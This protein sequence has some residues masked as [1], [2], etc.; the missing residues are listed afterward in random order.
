MRELYLKNE[1][2]EEFKLNRDVLIY[3]IE[4]LGI[5][6]ENIYFNYDL[7]QKGKNRKSNK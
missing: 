3:S 2:G 5:V 4:G 7:N 6:K 1:I